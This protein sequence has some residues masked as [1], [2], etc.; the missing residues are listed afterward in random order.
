MSGLLLGILLGPDLLGPRSPRQ[1][2][3]ARST[4]WPGR[5]SWCWRVSSSAGCPASSGG[6]SSTPGCWPR[7]SISCAP[8]RCSPRS[9]IGAPGL[10]HL[11]R[12]LDQR[13][14][15]A[16]RSPYH[17]SEAVIGL[18]GLL[19]AAGALAASFSGRLADRGLERWVSG[20]SLALIVGSIGLLA[21][22]S[23]QLWALVVGILSPTSVSR[24]PHPEPAAD[25]RHR[26]GGPVP[27]QHRVHG[28]LLHRRCLVRP[29]R[30]GLRRRRLAAVIMLGL[31][32]SRCGA[33]LW[34]D[35]EPARRR[36]GTRPRPDR[37]RAGLSRAN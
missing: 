20:G 8:S 24:R 7:W 21:L 3:G 4:W 10:R 22:G 17:Y 25:L 29:H 18:F 26:S 12:D 28:H 9:A 31:C 13:G 27:A 5:W 35:S 23:H 14:L 16:G 36:D 6:P 1:P 19:G 34:L 11:Q 2:D 15:P 30:P 37:P 33:G 32:F